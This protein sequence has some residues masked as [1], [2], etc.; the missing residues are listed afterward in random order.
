MDT[1]NLITQYFVN[2][3]MNKP[4]YIEVKNSYERYCVYMALQQYAYNWQSVWFNKSYK[5]EMR[6]AEKDT[7]KYCFRK[8]QNYEN[9]TEWEEGDDYYADESYHYKCNTC[10]NRYASIWSKGDA[11]FLE[12]IPNKINIF[13]C[14]KKKMRCFEH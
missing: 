4:N 12:K 2:I 11:M 6:Y 13:Y 5:K 7:C 3:V 10:V 1:K 9:I 14:L 8:K